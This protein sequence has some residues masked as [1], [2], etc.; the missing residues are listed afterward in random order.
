MKEYRATLTINVFI[1]AESEEDANDIFQDMNMDFSLDDKEFSSD[2]VDWEIVELGDEDEEY[3]NE[4]EE[5]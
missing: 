3:L 4:L 1:N 5:D 2:L